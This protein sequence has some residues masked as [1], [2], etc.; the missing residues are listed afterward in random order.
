MITFALSKGRLAN[1]IFQLLQNMN[2]NVSDF[3]ETSRKLIFISD[4]QKYR[5]FLAKPSDVPTYVDYGIADVG[6]VGKDTILTISEEKHNFSEVLDL[7]FG[8]CKMCVCGFHDAK[9]ILNSGNIIRVATK[10]PNIAKK[11]FEKTNRNVEI[12]KLNGSVE[13]GPLVGLSDVIVDI[14]ESGKTLKEN[15]LEILEEVDNISA[16]LIINN[17]SLKIKYQEINEL[18][19]GFNQLL[20]DNDD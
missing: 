15:G 13:L 9:N 14:V 7:S 16:R 3:K 12:I 1:K 2:I 5:F 8:K 19:N 17:A 20:G 18:I 6:V 10:Y 4:D 11:Y